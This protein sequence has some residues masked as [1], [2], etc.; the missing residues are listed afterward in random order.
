MRKDLDARDT[1]AFTRVFDALSAGMTSQRLQRHGFGLEDLA[2][3]M[4]VIAFVP[5][6]SG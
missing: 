5:V 6:N 2:R 1:S 4:H 3:A